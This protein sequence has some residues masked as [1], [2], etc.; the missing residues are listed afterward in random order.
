[1]SMLLTQALRVA[2]LNSIAFTGSGG[3]TTAMFQVARELSKSTPVVV[4]ASSH[5]GKWQIP[6]A[7]R[8]IVISSI[9]EIK[10]IDEKLSGIT[11]ITGD[12]DNDRTKPVTEEILTGLNIFCTSHSYPLLIEADGSRQKPF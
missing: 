6:L 5:L 4:T 12:L 9:D 3:K 11:L 1:M 10:V 8:H 2:N 7:D